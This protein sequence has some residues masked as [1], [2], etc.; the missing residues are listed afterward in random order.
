M[1][2]PLYDPN[3]P[4]FASDSYA[5]TQPQFLANFQALFNAFNQNHVPLNA[6]ANAGNHTFVNLMEQENDVQTG[7]SELSLYTLNVQGQTDQ[8]F[9]R[10]QGKGQV[11]QLTNY[12]IYNIIP[13]PPGQKG[14]FTS[15]PGKVMVYFGQIQIT[16]SSNIIKLLPAV[17]LN[18]ISVD[19]VQANTTGSFK[20]YVTL[21][22][23]DSGIVTEIALSSPL[24]VSGLFYYFVMA[25]I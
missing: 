3:T 19:L 14:Y 12:T 8:I 21:N 5:T 11:I 1:T 23:V 22:K 6:A 2:G 20:P 24:G 4:E 9:L 7:V 25:N 18:V 17:A 16:G 15:L 13:Q 10:N